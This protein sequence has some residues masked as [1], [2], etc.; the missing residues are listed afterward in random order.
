MRRGDLGGVLVAQAMNLDVLALRELLV[1]RMQQVMQLDTVVAGDD[2]TVADVVGEVLT[3]SRDA[4]DLL[5]EAIATLTPFEQ[6][7]I[8]KRYGVDR[9]ES[10]PGG[11]F[12]TSYPLSDRALFHASSCLAYDCIAVLF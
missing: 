6:A 10:R 8:R 7:Y 11:T 5:Q 3:S 9:L 12:G 4:A 1:L 2:L